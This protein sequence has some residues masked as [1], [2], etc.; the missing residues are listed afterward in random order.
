MH[1][2]I[3]VAGKDYDMLPLKEESR[4]PRMWMSMMIETLA[5][6]N[7]LRKSMEQDPHMKICVPKLKKLESEAK[8]KMDMVRW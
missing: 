2:N 6:I 7:E 8:F 4:S 3:C 1:A 5:S